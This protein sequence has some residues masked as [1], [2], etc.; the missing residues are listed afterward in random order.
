MDIALAAEDLAF[1]DEVR[2]FLDTEFDAEMQAH[3]KSRGSK[4]MI[5]WQKKLYAKGWVAP[6]LSLIHI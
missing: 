6:N 5:E 2:N 4:G 3:L 1:R